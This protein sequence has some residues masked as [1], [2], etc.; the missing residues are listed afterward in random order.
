M[1][2][3]VNQVKLITAARGSDECTY[4][5]YKRDELRFYFTVAHYPSLVAMIQVLVRPVF[6]SIQ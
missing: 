5:F 6:T 3:V 4:I 2:P 1:V